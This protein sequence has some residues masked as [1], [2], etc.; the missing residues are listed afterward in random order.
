[1]SPDERAMVD[2]TNEQRKQQELQPLTP[3]E[4]L[5]AAARKHSA[6]MASEKTL[7]HDLRG[8][9]AA[10]RVRDTGYRYFE[11]GEN[12]A[13][14]DPTPQVAVNA[15]MHSPP[16]RANILRNDFT[17]IGV[18]IARS[19]DGQ[20]YYTQV[21][22]RPQ[23]AGATA[24]ASFSIHNDT[25]QDLR[26]TLPGGGGASSIL[27]AGGTG[28]FTVSGSGDFPP[29]KLSFGLA[30]KEL[31]Y[32]DGGRYDVLGGPEGLEVKTELGSAPASQPR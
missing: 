5:F 17:E 24:K 21:F 1:M 30:E 7:S 25:G 2:A 18:G 19:A 12:I 28:Q 15:W 6:D 20:P 11:V 9:G 4:K 13:F 3:D 32:E 27:P 26:V 29:A 14:N 22:G 31:K 16:H 23:T 10:D 8:K